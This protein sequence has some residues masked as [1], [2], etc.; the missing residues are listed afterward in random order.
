MPG[1]LVQLE[2]LRPG[3]PEHADLGWIGRQIVVTSARLQRFPPLL[4]TLLRRFIHDRWLG[5]SEV[6]VLAA[7]GAQ[8]LGHAGVVGD[9][10]ELQRPVLQSH[11]VEPAMEMGKGKKSSNL[12]TSPDDTICADAVGLPWDA[13]AEVELRVVGAELVAVGGGG[14]DLPER[15]EGLG[16]GLH[17]PQLHHPRRL[18]PVRA[19]HL[20]GLGGAGAHGGDAGV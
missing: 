13:A 10:R 8:A 7:D 3:N 9:G 1:P 16:R 17:R 19:F 12:S 5:H 11:D 2:K 15:R 6:P 14:D 20:R 18:L 4:T